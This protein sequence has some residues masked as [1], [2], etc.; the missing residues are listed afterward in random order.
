MS[1][2]LE[3]KNI[4]KTKID[5]NEHAAYWDNWD[6]AR[7]Y[8]KQTFGLL[9]E[10]I[11]LDNLNI[12]DFGSGTGILTEY[13]AKSEKQVVA[14]DT[15][16]KMIEVLSN[17]KLNNVVTIVGQLSKET[18]STHSI[19][20]DKFDLI[21]ASSVCAFLPNYEEVLTIIKSLLKPNG[22][23]VQWDWLQK[24]AEPDFGFTEDMIRESYK[25]VGLK[26]ESINIPFSFIENEEKMDVIMAI[27]KSDKPLFTNR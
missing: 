22:I 4:D 14:V 21:V 7:D 26:I 6:E 19:L 23:F 25:F 16:E 5:W 8:T 12:L 20:K 13:M 11:N 9:T 1:E 18:I 3:R 24:D 15:S 10:K 17:K 27:G 2:E